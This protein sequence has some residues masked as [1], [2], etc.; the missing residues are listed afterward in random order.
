MKSLVLASASPRRR[1]ILAG[2]GLPFSSLAHDVDESVFDA[3]E[4]VVRVLDLARAKAEDCASKLDGQGNAVVLAADTLVC[5]PL[6]W[7]P[8]MDAFKDASGAVTLGKARD[9]GEAARMLALLSGRTHLVHTGLVLL[10]L[11]TNRSET[12]ISTSRVGFAELSGIEIEGYLDSGEWEGVAG[13]YRVQGLAALF[14]ER[15]EGSWSGIV[16]LPIH[17]LYA[18]LGR[19]GLELSSFR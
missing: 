4:P 13:A 8:S 19:L 3:R 6:P 16:G 18:T 11:G 12:A 9:R 1:E 14:I 10:D 5:D 15:I 2:L 17:E 7:H